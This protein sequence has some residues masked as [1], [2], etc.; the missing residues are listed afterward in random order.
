MTSAELLEECNK[1]YTNRNQIT[2]REY[3]LPINEFLMELYLKCTPSSYGKKLPLK[4]LGDCQR[5]NIYM[6]EIPDKE[7]CG[8][9]RICYP[10]IDGLSPGWFDCD[11]GS[12]TLNEISEYRIEI[13]TS[14]LTKND[15]YNI[16]GVRLYQE[17]DFY[18][19]CFIDCKDNFRP[20]FT[21]IDKDVLQNSDSITLT[22]LAG[23]AKTNINN[24]NIVYSATIRKD[25]FIYDMLFDNVENEMGYNLLKDDT[26]ESLLTFLSFLNKKAI[27]D[28]L[29]NSETKKKLIKNLNGR[30]KCIGKK[31]TY[32][33]K[34]MLFGGSQK[35]LIDN[36]NGIIRKYN[37]NE[38][39]LYYIPSPNIRE[40]R[41]KDT[42]R[43]KY[44]QY[45]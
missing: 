4:L 16:K 20:R 41:N 13:K 42:N 17:F 29:N 37:N 24:E 3:R 40:W 30:Y 15:V 2:S 31:Y 10:V 44:V 38:E 27:T 5:N 9:I 22:P 34:E 6:R 14:Y 26:Y 33:N 18:L 21:C 11:G 8:D 36:L 25:S 19:L 7:N 35:Q 12:T 1:K 45:P 39:D 43:W 23:T 32:L 28:Y